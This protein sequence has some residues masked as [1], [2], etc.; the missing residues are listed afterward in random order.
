ME[1][2]DRSWRP[3]IPFTLLFGIATSVELLQSRLLKSACR[4]IYG[5]QFDGVQRESTLE[6]IFTAAIASSDLPVRMGPAVL[7]WMLDRQRDQVAG[8]QLFVS[9][10]K[11]AYMCHFY[12]NPLSILCSER[13]SRPDSLQPE[14]LE[15]IRNMPSFRTHVE[16][17]IAEGTTDSLQHAKSLIESDDYLKHEIQTHTERRRAWTDERLRSL[18]ILEAAGLKMGGFARAY[19][20]VMHHGIQMGDSSHFV[21]SVRRMSVDKLQSTLRRV[22]QL[23]SEGDASLSLG[24]L[25]TGQGQRV[26]MGLEEQLSQLTDLRARADDAGLM[27][28]SKYMGHGKVMRTT[29]IAQKVQLSQDSATLNEEDKQL[30]SI[31]DAV[32]GLIAASRHDETVGKDVVFSEGWLYDSRNPSRD[33][34]VPRPR[35]VF[36]RSLSR[37]HDYLGCKCCAPGANGAPAAGGSLPAT[38]IL[39]QLYQETGNLINVADLWSAFHATVS[40][41]NNAEEEDEEAD[42]KALVMFYRGLAELRSLGYVKPSKKKTDHIAKVKWL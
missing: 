19:V 37:P 11:Y 34:F 28:R 23:L 24:G 6:T 4:H 10:L 31:I 38:A 9:S 13:G 1:Y 16:A 27:V 12:A 35:L 39:Y 36:Q 15:A 5:A 8:I 21:E 25:E 32:T 7:K 3:R 40:G 20:D 26:R 14:H 41:G 29:V 18:L 42:R 2:W 30:T 22:I 33:I 17:S